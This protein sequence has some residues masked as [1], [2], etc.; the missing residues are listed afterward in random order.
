MLTLRS[1]NFYSMINYVYSPLWNKYRP[2]LLKLMLAAEQGS[3]QYKFSGHEFKALNAKEKSYSFELRAFQGKAVNNIKSSIIAQE[4]L[5]VLNTSPK[6]SELMDSGTFQFVL[7]K[8]FV[9]HVS[10]PKPEPQPE[11]ETV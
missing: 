9:L 10:R 6:A 3:Q 7:D 8:K 1:N 5:E 11:T 2:A 4:L